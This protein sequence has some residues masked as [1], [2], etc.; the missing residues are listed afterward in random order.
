MVV[1]KNL[2]N[3]IVVKKIIQTGTKHDEFWKILTKFDL[4]VCGK[5]PFLTFDTSKKK[6]TLSRI[7]PANIYASLYGKA[8]FY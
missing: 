5:V 3:R 4:R 1:A 6:L 7:S 2:V 8:H